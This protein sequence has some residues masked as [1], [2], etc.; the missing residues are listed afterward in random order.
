MWIKN[1]KIIFILFIILMVLVGLVLRRQIEKSKTIEVTKQFTAQKTDIQVTVMATG[2]V[3]PESRVELKPSVYGRIDKVISQEG[4]NVKQGDIVAWMSSS[5]RAA[6]IDAARAQGKEEVERWEKIYPPMPIVAPIAGTIILKNIENGQT[7]SYNDVVYVMSNRLTIKAPVDES[8]LAQIKIGQKVDIRLDAYPEQLIEAKVERIAFEAKTIS[9]VTTYTVIIR[10]QKPPAVMRSGMTSNVVFYVDT[11]KD[12]IS[13]PTESIRYEGGKPYV[14]VLEG[15]EKSRTKKVEIEVGVSD[16]KQT[17]VKKGLSEGDNVVLIF[18][19]GKEKKMN[20]AFG[21]GGP[22]T[23]R[24]SMNSG[25]GM[26]GSLGGGSNMGNASSGG[27]G[28]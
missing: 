27:S 25:S 21:G 19:Y 6:L 1:K 2:T 4:D 11:K 9:N 17:E 20:N 15:P 26:S 3:Q 8:D 16:G 23:T 18:S 24:A 7:V 10:P 14:S 28:R 5:D 13:I 12:V 22:S